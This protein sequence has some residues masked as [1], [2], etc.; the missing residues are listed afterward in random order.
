MPVEI[1][2]AATE[3]VEKL[4]SKALDAFA[5]SKYGSKV[6]GAISAG[7]DLTSKLRNLASGMKES[8][9]A[10]EW[11]VNRL[12][13]VYAPAH[14][15]ALQAATNKVKQGVPHPRAGQPYTM[16]D[17]YAEARNIARVTTFGTNDALG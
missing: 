11:T 12:K 3:A 2:E 4:G 8:G 9:P 7:Y 14:D 15:R 16:P 6:A 5:Q 10:G 1:P 13:N 17:A